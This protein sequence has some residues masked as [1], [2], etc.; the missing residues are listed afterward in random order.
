[1]G[2]GNDNNG[3][4][5]WEH[6][7]LHSSNS[8]VSNMNHFD[9]KTEPFSSHTFNPGN[10]TPP[11][12][13]KQLEE[14]LGTPPPPQQQQQQYKQ[15]NQQQQQ[16]PQSQQKE[17]QQQY[18]QSQRGLSSS[19]SSMGSSSHSREPIIEQRQKPRYATSLNSGR[20]PRA[21][22]GANTSLMVQNPQP[23]PPKKKRKRFT[24]EEDEKIIQGVQMYGTSWEQILEWSQLDRTKEQ[25]S[26]RFRRIR[27]DSGSNGSDE[28]AHKKRR[29]SGNKVYTNNNST[30]RAKE[31]NSY[32]PSNNSS[33]ITAS[34]S[35]T[36]SPAFSTPGS[37][38]HDQS[39]NDKHVQL[40]ER[41]RE[42]EEKETRLRQFEEQLHNEQRAI[43]ESQ[44]Q[45]DHM[46]RRKLGTQYKTALEERIR[47][48]ARHEREQARKEA[49]K[50]EIRIGKIVDRREGIN[51]KPSWQNGTAFE[52]V[53]LQQ[54]DIQQE[55][56]RLDKRKKQIQRMKKHKNIAS[57]SDDPMNSEPTLYELLEEEEIIKVRLQ[58]LKKEEASLQNDLEKLEMKKHMHWKEIKRIRDED[59]SRFNN[60]PV[61]NGRYLLTHLLGKGGFSEV[62]KAYDLDECRIVACKIHQLHPQWSEERKRNYIKHARREYEIHKRLNH[63]RVIRLFDMFEIDVNTFSTVL[64]FCD[65]SDLDHYLTSRK[66]LYEREARSIMMQ[67]FHGLKYLN[68]QKQRIIHY[69]LKPANILLRNGE[70]KI[71][72]FGLSKIM[73]EDV[74]DLELTSPGAGT[75]WYLPPECL[76]VGSSAP[77]ISSKVDV[78]SAGV[79]F[80]QVLYGRKPFGHGV[81][82]Q[83]FLADNIISQATNIDFPSKPTVSQEAKD[84]IRLC[85]R[86]RQEDRPDVDGAFSHPYIQQPRK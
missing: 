7:S 2:E 81:S 73:E 38:F 52:E 22:G 50:N 33:N 57:S 27:N 47:T 63:P 28:P 37:D 36:A 13:L 59:N 78:W 56:D 67:V 25:I 49:T 71:T 80:Y 74:T 48:Q 55:K 40:N 4:V 8:A 9:E 45:Q 60:C 66:T 10:P 79:V 24:P 30:E 69:D 1:M 35:T 15:I 14:K 84:F 58:N 43:S 65:G 44:K 77:K 29:T 17:Q 6:V 19:S 62:Y 72:D 85:L 54:E 18:K 39:L 83:T 86:Y 53:Y 68:Q 31:I 11:E 23:Y 64:E 20:S 82:Q 32:Q 12:Q 26:S 51:I 46:L 3:F 21:S 41:E 42:L 76:Q 16:I 61:L 70:V 75:Y 34:S 5:S